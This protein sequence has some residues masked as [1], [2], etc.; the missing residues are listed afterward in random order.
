MLEFFTYKKVKKHKAEKKA[1][2]DAI[3]AAKQ[4]AQASSDGPDVGK[5]GYNKLLSTGRVSK[6]FKI[7]VEYASGNAVS[8]L[9]E[10][11]SE[12]IVTAKKE[13]AVQ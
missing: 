11:G 1:K 9:K 2:E 8:K 13:A 10:S 3:E 5:L 12:V 4:E 6:K 7:T